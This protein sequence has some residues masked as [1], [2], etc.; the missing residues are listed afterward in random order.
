MINANFNLYLPP[1][2]D[3]VFCMASLRRD[4]DSFTIYGNYIFGKNVSE[5]VFGLAKKYGYDKVLLSSYLPHGSERFFK[6]INKEDLF[7]VADSLTKKGIEA[8]VILD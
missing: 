6:K 1:I 7:Q 3:A 8:K 4:S 2:G 5:E